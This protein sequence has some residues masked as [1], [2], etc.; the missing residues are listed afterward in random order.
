MRVSTRGAAASS[1]SD[2]RIP[3]VTH[4]DNADH[5]GDSYDGQQSMPIVDGTTNIGGRG[6]MERHMR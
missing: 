3:T 5:G 4:E 2:R 6:F 1:G